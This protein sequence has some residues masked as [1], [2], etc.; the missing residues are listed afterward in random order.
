MCF[1]Y[2]IG[3]ASATSNAYAS[4]ATGSTTETGSTYEREERK[5]APVK[6][7]ALLGT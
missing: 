2:L 4:P 7:Q 3:S 6:H 5:D 1:N